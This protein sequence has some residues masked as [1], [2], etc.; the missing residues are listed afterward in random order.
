V[1]FELVVKGSATDTEFLGG[2]FLVS[3]S[4]GKGHQHKFFLNGIKGHPGM[5]RKMLDRGIGF[6]SGSDSQREKIR[7]QLSFIIAPRAE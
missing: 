4:G 6:R 1:L 7:G 2:L 5:K 3:L